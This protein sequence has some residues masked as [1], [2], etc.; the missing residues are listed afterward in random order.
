MCLLST[1]SENI[2]LTSFVLFVLSLFTSITLQKYF[3]LSLFVTLFILKYERYESCVSLLIIINSATNFKYKSY[4]F[5]FNLY[6][7]RS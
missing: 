3:P 6:E 5:R 4:Y 7:I 2:G 1:D